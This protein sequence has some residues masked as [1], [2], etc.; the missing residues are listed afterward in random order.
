MC[1]SGD[2]NEFQNL[3]VEFAKALELYGIDCEID[4]GIC[5]CI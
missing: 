5:V 4:S 1:F 2:L 3:A